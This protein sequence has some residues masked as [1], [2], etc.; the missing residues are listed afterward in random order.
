MTWLAALIGAWVGFIA[1][2]LL[3]GLFDDPL[4]IEDD[5]Q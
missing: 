3:R 5:L 4:D 2:F 1:G